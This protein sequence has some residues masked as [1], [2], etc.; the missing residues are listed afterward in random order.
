MDVIKSRLSTFPSHLPAKLRIAHATMNRKNRDSDSVAPRRIVKTFLGSC[1]ILAAL[2]TVACGS[3]SPAPPSMPSM[4][5]KQIHTEVGDPPGDA[6]S[7]SRIQTSPDIVLGIVDV[8]AG[9]VVF[10]LRH[11]SGTFDSASARFTIDLDTDQNGSTGASGFEFYV[12]IFPGDRGADVARTTSTSYTVV[13]TVPVSFV[14]DGCDV[15]VPLSLLGDDDGRFDFRVRVYAE[16]ALPI[17]LD[18]MPDVGLA[19]VQ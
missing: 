8:E 3:M 19:H 12:F 11:R 18:F 5:P 15:T 1:W 6:I 7:D 9:N 14:A 10:R 13:G 4:A 2:T 16:P 17:V